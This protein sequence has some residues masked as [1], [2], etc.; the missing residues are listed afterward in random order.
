MRHQVRNRSKRFPGNYR[1][2]PVNSNQVNQAAFLFVAISGRI[3]RAVYMQI[4]IVRPCTPCAHSRTEQMRVWNN[5][6]AFEARGCGGHC[7]RSR[8]R[9]CVLL[10]V[11]QCTRPSPAG[12]PQYSAPNVAFRVGSPI[13]GARRLSLAFSCSTMSRAGGALI[14]KKGSE[15]GV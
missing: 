3:H 9:K 2:R 12:S 13:S 8:R 6:A 4:S 7:A 1:Y 5:R 15:R 11:S 14:D 10:A